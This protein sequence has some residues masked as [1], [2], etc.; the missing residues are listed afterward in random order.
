M[1][2]VVIPLAEG[3]ADAQ[4][5]DWLKLVEK[6]LKGAGVETL[7][8]RSADGVAIQPLYRTEDAPGAP[9]PRPATTGWDV[10]VAVRH[11]DAAAA[12]AEA[13]E[14]LAGGGASLLLILDPTGADGVTIGSAEDMARVLDSVVTDIAPVALDAGF[15][16][17]KAADWLGELAKASPAAPLQFHLDPLS[18]FARTGASPGPIQS[19]L[20][21]AAN[22]A[23]RLAVTYPKAGLFL[24]SGQAA[25]E[26]GA[27]EAE[28]IAFAAA[29][30]LA[31]AKALV[32]AG[33]PMRDAFERITLGLAADA[34]YFTSIAKLRA[35]RLV[36]AQITTACGAEVPA[37]IEARSSGRML[38]RTD[39][40]TNLIRLTA[41]GFAAAVGGADAL[42]L[43]AFTDAL[44]LPT[45]FAR[46]QARNTQLV[47]A[48][49]AG[50]GRVND[51]AAGTWYLERLTG[52]LAA[53]AWTRFQAI[54]AAGGIVAALES[55]LIAEGA[56]A[57]CEALT[58]RIVAG[59]QKILGVT[60]FRNPDLA[61]V[62]V[63]TAAP[64]P[65]KA[66]DPRLPGPDSHCPPLTP[67]RFEDLAA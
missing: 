11:P 47:L 32:R 27:T 51:P 13:L 14:G 20:I 24:A 49:E 46:R 31:Y 38:A 3:F 41:A 10:R 8:G 26:A 19:H 29:A 22:V 65:V 40:W 44:G 15:L 21:S 2:N 34:E 61:P 39:P 43:G 1:D 50:L 66:P 67:I 48:E 23:A 62:E 6:T 53:A 58:A 37:R 36:W 25:H 35:A 60:Q 4:R 33:L 56:T 30:A 45:A 52:D 18:A 54:E 42:V 9:T 28:E 7:V 64:T 63:E 59:D 57:A 16:G 55:G 12:N 17:A 5:E